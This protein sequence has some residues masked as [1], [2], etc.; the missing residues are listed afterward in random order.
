MTRDSTNDA[1][2]VFAP[3][4]LGDAVMALPAIADVRRARPGA[5]IAVAAR[6]SVA[7]L[8]RLVNIVDEIV[9][10]ERSRWRVRAGELGDRRFGTALLLPN[11]LQS[12]VLAR[13]AHIPERWGYRSDCRGP[14]LTRA[15]E[16]P[17]G[18]HQVDYYRRLVEALGFPNGDRRPRVNVSSESRAAASALLRARGWNGVAPLAAIAPGAAYGGAKRWAPESFAALASAWAG[19]GVDVVMVGTAADRDTADCVARAFAAGPVQGRD[20]VPEPGALHD[21]VGAT[22]LQTLAGIFAMCRALV[23]NDS[24]A[25]HLAAAIGTPVTA[26]FGPTNERATAPI[27]D[28][29]AIVVGHAWCRPC[30][31]REC[32]IDHRCMRSIEV[33]TVIASARLS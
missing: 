20:R 23:S 11:S 3:N 9:T 16:R 1:L 31:L 18:A 15:V 24:G 27:G 6:S 5:R 14:L 2:V 7:P 33:G 12:A 4:W 8:F 17:K 29:H 21:L 19:D 32:P 30:M 26:V 13:Q 25:M 28:E 22:D 10:F